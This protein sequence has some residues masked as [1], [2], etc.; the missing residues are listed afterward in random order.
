VAQAEAAEQAADFD[1]LDDLEARLW[2]DGPTA[3]E[4]RVGGDLRALFL[5]MNGRALRAAHPGDPRPHPEGHAQCLAEISAFV[6]DIA[7]G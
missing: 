6:D 7:R 3:P 5:E 4:G 2:L 1:A